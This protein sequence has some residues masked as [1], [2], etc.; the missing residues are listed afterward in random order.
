MADRLAGFVSLVPIWAW[1]LFAF[2]FAFLFW[3]GITEYLSILA[4]WPLLQRSFQKPHGG[5]LFKQRL[6]WALMGKG[7]KCENV[8]TIAAYRGGVGL[9][10]NSFFGLLTRPVLVPWAQVSACAVEEAQTKKETKPE[11]VRV[12]F[13]EL[14]RATVVLP[15][16]CW[17]KIETHRPST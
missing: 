4:G 14:E 17:S 10:M 13:G 15:D 2:L 11:L 7:V 3:F 16:E 5:V 1:G 9:E 12:R 8:L 6:K